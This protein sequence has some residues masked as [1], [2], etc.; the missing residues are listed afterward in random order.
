MISKTLISGAFTTIYVFTAELFPS[1]MRSA[2]ISLTNSSGK[3]VGLFT[4]FIAYLAIYRQ[5]LPL[6]I[7]GILPTLAGPLLLL[8]P[9]TRGEPLPQTLKDVKQM[10]RQKNLFDKR[11]DK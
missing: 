11:M 1:E 3:I 10:K 8:L 2:V 7:F 4:P 5:Y 9:E 6:L